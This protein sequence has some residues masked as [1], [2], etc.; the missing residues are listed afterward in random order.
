MVRFS[1]KKDKDADAGRHPVESSQ[2]NCR[3]ERVRQ[4]KGGECCLHLCPS[5]FSFDCASEFEGWK[6]D[7]ISCIFCKLG[8]DVVN[9]SD[10][11]SAGRTG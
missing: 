10:V 9:I 7:L 11:F 2:K 8:G 4:V 3:K 6:R 5:T 1:V